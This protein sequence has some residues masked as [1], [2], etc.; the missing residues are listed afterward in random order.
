MTKYTIANLVLFQLLW[1]ACVWVTGGLGYEWVAVAAMVPLVLLA[2]MGPTRTTDLLVAL[3]AA[4]AGLL[5]D[6]V[7][8]SIGLLKF[9]GYTL[10]P[11]WI[12]FLW[13]GMGLTLNHSMRWFRDKRWLG[14]AIV[15]VFGPVTYFSGERLG[16]VEVEKSMLLGLI[17]V[18]WFLL[19]IVLSRFSHWMLDRTQAV[20]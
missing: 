6:N 11:F 7:W 2:C 19:F 16:A 8:V 5:L 10:A 18:S 20:D 12:G 3:M 13:F 4:S 1:L 14:P 15:G 9:T 17:A